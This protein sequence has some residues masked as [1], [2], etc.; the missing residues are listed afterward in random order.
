M[1]KLKAASKLPSLTE[2]RTVPSLYL[3]KLNKV[4]TLGSP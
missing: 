2:V 3:V 4:T 1:N